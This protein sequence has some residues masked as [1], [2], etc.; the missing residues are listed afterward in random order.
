MDLAGTALS[1]L[2]GFAAGGPAGAALGV[3]GSLYAD[4]KQE[5]ARNQALKVARANA[6][7]SPFGV[8]AT[9][10]LPNEGGM[11]AGFGFMDLLNRNPKLAE[12]LN[13]SWDRLINTPQEGGGT[14]AN[15][16]ALAQYLKPE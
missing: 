14:I 9:N 4:Q 8:S 10:V 15:R 6:M 5:E 11:G 16:M 7:L 3:A 1:G 2:M 12:K 13:S